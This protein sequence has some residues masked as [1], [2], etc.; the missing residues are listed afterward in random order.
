MLLS[1]DSVVGLF[2]SMSLVK[3]RQLIIIVFLTMFLLRIIFYRKDI[4][5]IQE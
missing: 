4:N 2:L 5:T 3:L 1:Y